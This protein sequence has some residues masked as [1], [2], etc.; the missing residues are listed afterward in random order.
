MFLH[1]Q[2]DFCILNKEAG[3]KK[4]NR[5]LLAMLALPCIA[6]PMNAQTATEAGVDFSIRFYDRRVYYTDGD[7][8]FIQATITNRS[9]YTYRFKLADDRL[10][11]LDFDVR[12]TANR[13]VEPADLLVRRRTEHQQVFFREIAVETGESFSF[14]E[15]LRNF[16]RLNDPGSFVIWANIHPELIRTSTAALPANSEPGLLQSQ[17]L[18]LTIR[19]PPVEGPGG[20]PLEM[21]VATGAVLVRERL[22]P[23]QVVEY[24]LLARQKSQWERF[25]LY[26]DLETMLSQDGV[27][28]RRW[29]AESEEGRR[30][31]IELFRQELQSGTTTDGISLVPSEFEIERTQYGRF[32]GSVTVLQ[33][34]KLPNFT[35]LKRFTY[36]LR[37]KDNIWTIVDY[38]VVN[39]GV[40]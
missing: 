21:E 26:I 36:Y 10:F 34:F 35:E 7:P 19:R 4:L 17:R 3:M 25:F 30:R 40:E 1:I 37:F 11:S 2:A 32:E 31:M 23:D 14:V 24:M 29:L 15:D 20:I 9:P 22:A 18:S 16:V 33:K 38:S 5:L 12:T 8:I 28:R 13:A 27:R 39:L 6:I